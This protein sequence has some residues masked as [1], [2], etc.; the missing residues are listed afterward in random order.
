MWWPIINY[1][2]AII[3]WQV[4]Y[5]FVCTQNLTSSLLPTNFPKLPSFVFG[6]D[7]LTFGKNSYLF[8]QNYYFSCYLKILDRLST[9]R[10][11]MIVA[12]LK[13]TFFVLDFS[14]AW[15]VITALNYAVRWLIALL[16]S[17]VLKLW[18]V[19]VPSTLILT[20][21]QSQL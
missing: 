4:T 19:V 2:I 18:Q 10:T 5:C 7:L 20:G 9:V 14:V 15:D 13:Q 16:K 8:V 21:L 17:W 1:D 3:E 6:A 12:S 11:W